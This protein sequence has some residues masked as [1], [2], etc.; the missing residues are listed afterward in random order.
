MRVLPPQSTGL[1][2]AAL[3]LPV[4]LSSMATSIANVALP[5]LAD[6]FGA[7]FAAVQWIVL[8]YLVANTALL[9]TVGRLGDIVGKRR[10]LIAGLAVFTLASMLCAVAPSLWIL[11]AARTAQGIGA[12]MM[13]ALAMAFV[14]ETVAKEKT[15]RAMGLLGTTSALGTALGPALGGVL[16]AGAGW[17]AI[18]LVSMALG[19]VAGVLAWRH[20][21]DDRAVHAAGQPFDR[22]GA[23]LLAATV[24]A[25]ALAATWGGRTMGAANVALL[26]AGALGVALFIAAERAAPS[27]LLPVDLLRH[28]RVR[29]GTVASALVATV[30]MATLVVGPFHL[31]GAL[32]LDAAG[33]GLVMSSGPIVAALAGIPAGRLAD[34]V[35]PFRVVVCG[36]LAMA[37]GTALLSLLAPHAGVTGY[38]VSLVVITGGYALFQAANTTAV[39]TAVPAAQRGVASGV[40]N[41]ARS[42]GLVSGA[43]L[44]GAVFALALPMGDVA[45]TAPAGIAS[46]TRLVFA[47]A[48]GLVLLALALAVAAETSIRRDLLRGSAGAGPARTS[49]GCAAR[50]MSV[51]RL[52]DVD[53]GDAVSWRIRIRAMRS[54][55]RCGQCP[56]STA[57]DCS[58]TSARWRRSVATRPACI[59]RIS[60]RRTSRAGDG[61]WRGWPRPASTPAST[62]SARSSARAGARDHAC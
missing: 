14:G 3:A 45:A 33:V 18:F 37:A 30:V 9:V 56:R 49:R 59:A 34:R 11:I 19:L 1:T 62:G 40:L 26:A 52:L 25:F 36:L 15:G 13:I 55:E 28:A 41:L 8:A 60:R 61:W 32:G 7:S 29:A 35:G 22:A 53:A 44:M 39:M 42:L 48:T 10:A 5:T 50:R 46:G 31:A 38:V 43:S 23:L 57:R 2:M 51:P 54:E 27:P 16:I 47:L 12:A 24:A 20:L 17:R 58:Q 21:P 4:M 6:A